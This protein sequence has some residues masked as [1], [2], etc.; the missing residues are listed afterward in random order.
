V[1]TTLLLAAAVPA[2]ETPLIDFDL[3]VLIQLVVFVL[4]ALILSRFLFRP[5]LAMRAARSEGIEGAREQA[6]RMDDEAKAKIVDY[7]ARFAKA[8]TRANDERAK[9]RAEA[10]SREREITDA[11][12][13]DTDATLEAARKSLETDA[14]AAR[15]A[16]APRADEIA[17]SIVKKVLGREVA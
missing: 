11:A 17:R 10:A 15:Q 4:T 12:R 3:T 8:R 9:V 1:H 2:K 13:K 5:F 14:T 6:T 7:D 16:L